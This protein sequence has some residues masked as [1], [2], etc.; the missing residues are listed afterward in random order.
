MS[1][2]I[3]LKGLASDLM[4]DWL[5]S[6][7]GRGEERKWV[8]LGGQHYPAEF[9]LNPIT[10]TASVTIHFSLFFTPLTPERKNATLKDH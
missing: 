8:Q 5:T 9:K 1:D 10:L 7:W 3:I 6:Q 4:D 2:S